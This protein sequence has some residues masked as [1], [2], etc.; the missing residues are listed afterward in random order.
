MD[1]N[2]DLGEG[3]PADR[4]LLEIVTSASVAC[5]F[6][7]GD[8]VTMLTTAR[9]AADRGVAVGAHPSYLDREGFGR[10]QM[11]IS[12]RELFAAV[13]YQ[14]G[15]M[16]AAATAAGTS[17]AYV[18]PHGA[19]YNQAASD[20]RIAEPVVQAVATARV[21][22]LCPLGSEMEKLGRQAGVPVYA[23]AFADRGYQ[24]DGTLVP[25]D[26]PGCV[27]EDPE[28]VARRAVGISV[29]G[30]LRA[31]DG[32]ILAVKADSLCIHGDTPGAVALARSVR[33]ALE[34]AGV[35]IR[36]FAAP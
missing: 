18:K 3:G 15:A 29:R 12:G 7:A 33:Q 9:M 23:E 22:L 19:L 10:R 26:S 34:D 11:T 35:A 30:E 14:V 6:H 5:G 8:P 25:R 20:P 16:A 32:S 1:L 24:A 2:A 36:P 17:L 13:V 21:P 31:Q 27:L 4:E 28:E